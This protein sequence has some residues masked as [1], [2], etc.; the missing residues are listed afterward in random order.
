MFAGNPEGLRPRYTKGIQQIP[1]TIEALHT[2]LVAMVNSLAIGADFYP[3]CMGDI[4]SGSGCTEIRNGKFGTF[5]RSQQPYRGFYDQESHSPGSRSENQMQSRSVG[6][7]SGHQ[8]TNKR[9][10]R[11]G[12]RALKEKRPWRFKGHYSSG[13][14]DHAAPIFKHAIFSGVSG[15]VNRWLVSL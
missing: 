6:P 1:F 2:P 11:G 8:P 7:L 10:L 9:P 14:G 5:N 15:V 13:S 4:R 12:V 3:A